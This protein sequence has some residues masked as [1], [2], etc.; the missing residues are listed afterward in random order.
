MHPHHPAADRSSVRQWLG[1]RSEYAVLSPHGDEQATVTRP[2]QIGISFGQHHRLVRSVGGRTVEGDVPAGSTV[3]TGREG[4]SWLRVREPTE[5]LEIYV[6]PAVLRRLAAPWRSG[7]VE[8]ELTVGAP[9]GV[10]L[11]I[12]TVL[13]RVH[14]ADAYLSDVAASALTH[15]LAAHLLARYCGVPAAA[16]AA[17][18]GALDARVVDRVAQFVEAELPTALTLDRLAAVAGFSSFHFARAFRQATGMPPH[19]FVTARRIDRARN[20]LRTT[21]LP[22][23][24]VAGAVGFANLSHFRRVFRHH[25]G[26]APAEFRR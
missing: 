2:H 3:V 10:V 24:Q 1:M 16:R 8:P 25:T 7:P 11:G 4:I 13:R 20:L 17:A 5:A 19:G 22:V 12:G 15:R 9:D 14:A 6:E 26:R 21:A 18:A 23:A